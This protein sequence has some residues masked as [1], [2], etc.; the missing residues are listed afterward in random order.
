MFPKPLIPSEIKIDLPGVNRLMEKLD[1]GLFELAYR[2]GLRDGVMW[3]LVCVLCVGA[4]ILLL[5]KT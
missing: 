1:A 4:V 2:T 5:R 3:T